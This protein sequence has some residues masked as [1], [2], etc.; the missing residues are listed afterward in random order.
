MRF[1]V[2][3]TAEIYDQHIHRMIIEHREIESQKPLKSSTTS[4][5]DCIDD[6]LRRI[7]VRCKFPEE[8]L[9]AYEIRQI[10]HA[11]AL[12]V[13]KYYA[14]HLLS[15]DLEQNTIRSRISR[16]TMHEC[17]KASSNCTTESI[18]WNLFGLLFA[19]FF[20]LSRDDN[21]LKTQCCITFRLDGQER[22]RSFL[23]CC[24]MDVFDLF[25]SALTWFVV[26]LFVRKHHVSWISPKWYLQSNRRKMWRFLRWLRDCWH[27]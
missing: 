14:K 1:N 6:E 19:I 22:F 24:E 20:S 13:V 9:R 2:N 7:A 18:R 11:V 10:R 17:K 26:L 3:E 12:S 8:C 23:R 27:W 15:V 4:A 25:G 16:K 5:E 21:M